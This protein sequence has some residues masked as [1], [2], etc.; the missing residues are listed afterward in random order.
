MNIGNNYAFRNAERMEQVG[1][2]VATRRGIGTKTL[3]M[4]FIVMVSAITMISNLWRLGTNAL[5]IYIAVCIANAVIQLII[6]FVPNTTKV[7]AIPYSILEGLSLGVVVGILELALGDGQGFEL[8][9]LALVM[10][11]AVFFAAAL[12]YSTG[13][14]KAGHMFRSIM[15]TILFGILLSSLVISILSIFM[16]STIVSMFQTYGILI[17]TLL[18]IV[19]GC[20]VV[21]SLD[22]AN[23]IVDGG[24]PKKFEWFAAYGIVINIVW[25]FLEVL[26]L[27]MYLKNDNNS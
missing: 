21:I 1:G 18:V 27:L 6:C 25:L 11:I 7:L 26:R 16:Y 3:L 19:A 14:I 5:G 8:A 23:R 9:G 13:V 12:L 15:L 20:Y 22:N 17:S 4:L 2:G 24:A 10:T